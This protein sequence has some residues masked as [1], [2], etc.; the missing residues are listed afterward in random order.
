MTTAAVR[1]DLHGFHDA[2]ATAPRASL[3]VLNSRACGA[4][5]LRALWDASDFRVCA[6]GGAN[7]V[8]DLLGLD[9]VPDAIVGDFDSAR[10]E[11]VDAYASR[12]CRVE[13]V[14]DQDATD[15]EKALGVVGARWDAAGTD[16]GAVRVAGAFGTRFDHEMA[17]IQA[18]YGFGAARPNARATLHGDHAAACLLS[19]DLRHELLV[20]REFEGPH[21]G[22]LPI[23]G[24]CRRVTTTGLTWN[25][26]GGRLAFGELISSSN[27]VPDG[28]G[29]AVVTVETTE[30]LVWTVET[31][32]GREEA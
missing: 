2:A 15:L 21:C 17:A 32:L 5:L 4:D 25:L 14:R 28:A 12:G 16:D 30:P 1:H 20:R 9:A 19:A 23:G 10:P 24:P 22:L 7:R 6:D 27:L 8:H 26:D 18:L 31:R 11:V 13:R 3:I 29:D